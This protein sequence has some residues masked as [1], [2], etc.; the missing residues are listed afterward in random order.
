[1]KSVALVIAELVAELND[2]V[3]IFELLL[4]LILP[5][6]VDCDS[7]E[8]ID[9]ENGI[10]EEGGESELEVTALESIIDEDKD[11][12]AKEIIELELIDG[13]IWESYD[14]IADEVI[15]TDE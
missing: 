2:E 5:Y 12:D 1:M 15:G 10:E 3:I 6:W 7:L 9:D 14:E 13:N 11:E 8:I 4:L